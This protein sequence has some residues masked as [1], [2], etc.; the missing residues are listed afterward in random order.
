MG[1][2][3]SVRGAVLVGSAQEPVRILAAFSW[4]IGYSSCFLDLLFFSG[5]NL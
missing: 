5:V 4:C 3:M 1:D 2:A